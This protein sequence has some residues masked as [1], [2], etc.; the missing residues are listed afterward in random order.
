MQ[1]N[2]R[3]WKIRAL[4][5]TLGVLATG[6]YAQDQTAAAQD[7]PPAE[8]NVIQSYCT[9]CHNF[10]DWAGSIAFDVMSPDSIPHDAKVWEEVIR[11]LKG[12]LMP[13]PG[14]KRPDAETVMQVA[15]WLE[16]AEERRVGEECVSTGKIR[17][18]P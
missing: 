4:G 18:W 14:K 9:D 10:E 11:K 13:P 5:V 16:R 7:Q 12:G 17:G 3:L 6:A 8:W 1:M 2:P 15:N